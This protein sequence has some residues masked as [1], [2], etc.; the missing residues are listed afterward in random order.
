MK[1]RRLVSRILF[2]SLLIASAARFSYETARAHATG[3]EDFYEN[4]NQATT[5]VCNAPGGLISRLRAASRTHEPSARQFA[6][7]GGM[8][9]DAFEW[10][11][12]RPHKLRGSWSGRS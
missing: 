12:R 3:F 7:V 5:F 1:L 4:W 10:E 11:V 9:D 8:S 6:K 2:S